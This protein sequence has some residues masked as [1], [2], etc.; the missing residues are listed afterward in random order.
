MASSNLKKFTNPGFLRSLK[1]S[2][3]IKLLRKFDGYFSGVV[4]FQYDNIEQDKFDFDGL[5]AILIDQMMVGD[6]SELFNAFGLIGAMGTDSRED[7]LREYIDAQPYKDEVTDDTAVADL[8]LLVYLHAPEVLNDIDIEFNATKK[9]SFA[10]R[11][12]RRNMS[13]LVITHQHIVA[14]EEELNKIFVTRH[15][16]NTAKV[17]TP[18]KEGDEYYFIIRHGD[19]FKRQGTV[20][21]GKESRTLAFQ[22]ESFNLLVLN[23]K[24]GELRIC[25]PAQP[26]WMEEGYA[27]TLGKALF[28]DFAAFDEKRCNNLER[29]KE[30]GE[31]VLIY[32]GTADVRKISLIG[33]TFWSTPECHMKETLDA[34]NDALFQDFKILDRDIAGIGTIFEARFVVQI[35]DKERTVVIKNNNRSGYDYDDFGIVVDEWLRSVGI[36]P[37]VHALEVA[38]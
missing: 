8:A 7:V 20:S 18:S 19:S 33:L 34:S 17:Y 23:T 11:A 37:S 21:Q 25:V 27:L 15:R 31:K 4:H 13:D 26:K 14:F 3:L 2:N 22:P 24:T 6:Y 5:A 28:N 29:I 9:K 30:L 38:A 36:I 16:G 32:N 35:G 10:M 12:T 1:F